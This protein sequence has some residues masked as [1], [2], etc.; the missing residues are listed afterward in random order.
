[1][2]L[3]FNKSTQACLQSVARQ[4]AYEELTQELRLPDGM[5]DIGRVLCSWAQIV[6]RSKEWRGNEVSVSGGVMVWALYAP[7]DGSE[8]RCMDSWIPFQLKWNLPDVGRE[9]PVRICPLLRFV[10]SRTVSARKM[11]TRVGIAAMG[12]ALCPMEREVY[13]PGELPEDVQVL[14][15]TYPVRLPR[16]AGEKT[17]LLDEDLTM[18]GSAAQP[19]KLLGHTIRTEIQDR[20]VMANKI[21]FRGNAILHMI[22]RCPE[23]RIHTWDFEIPF[24]QFADLDGEYSPDARVD[25]QTAATNLKLDLNE[26]GAL[27]LKCGLVAQYLVDDR[28][29]LELTEDA[30]SPNRGVSMETEK[31]ELPVVLEDRRESLSASQSLPGQSGDVV[32]VN[33]L[34]D[35]PRQRQSADGIELE[36][37]GLFQVLYYGEDGAL[38]SGNARWEGH[39]QLPAGE[40]SRV[41]ALV[42]PMGKAQG[43]PGTDGIDLDGEMQL[44]LSTTTDRGMEM[45]K[46]LELGELQE[47]DPARPSMVLCRMGD[48]GLWNLAKRCGSTVGA[49]QK[50]NGLS[51]EPARDRMLLVPIA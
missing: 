40:D 18:P 22:Y 20:K 37:P 17:F 23:G 49:I 48:E 19:A 29:L 35:F 51:E 27:R 1:M 6:L 42:R 45:V 25:I 32:D 26:Q 30:Y 16:E 44:Q 14:R 7:E 21:V 3:Q 43:R 36:L 15:R 34:P 2:E 5:P 8:P 24:S 10:D 28:A 41:T 12:E 39:M 33:F 46:G 11:M 38:Q 50:A 31:L 9:G 47:P 4:V 13:S